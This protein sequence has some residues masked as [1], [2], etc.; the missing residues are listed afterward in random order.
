MSP[1][2]IYGCDSMPKKMLEFLRSEKISFKQTKEPKD[3]AEKLFWCK[4][5]QSQLTPLN[6]DTLV[7][8]NMSD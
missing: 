6:W 2:A 4:C 5:C 7:P 8:G 3:L 1:T